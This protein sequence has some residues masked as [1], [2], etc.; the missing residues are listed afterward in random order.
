MS[1]ERNVKFCKSSGLPDEDD[2][3]TIK[4]YVS[5]RMGEITSDAFFLMDMHLYVELRDSTIT[6]LIL[7]N[8]CRRRQPSRLVVS[9]WKDA[10]NDNWLDKKR[11]KEIPEEIKEVKITLQSH[12]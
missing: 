3:V 6:R 8:G 10:E 5:E 2:A 4:E 12:S 9:D 11:L 7:V 1:V